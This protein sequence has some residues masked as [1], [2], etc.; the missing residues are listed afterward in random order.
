MVIEGAMNGS[1]K[2]ERRKKGG[3]EP[4]TPG[5]SF[6][7]GMVLQVDVYQPDGCS[8]FCGRQREAVEGNGSMAFPNSE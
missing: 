1:W 4:V 7:K 8:A 6:Q 3:T 5:L 2:A